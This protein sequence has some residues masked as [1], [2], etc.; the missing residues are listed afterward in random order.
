[1][2]IEFKETGKGGELP[3]LIR[4]FSENGIKGWK[5]FLLHFFPFKSKSRNI[6]SPPRLFREI[7]RNPSQS[8]TIKRKSVFV[9]G[10]NRGGGDRGRGFFFSG[11]KID[12][13][14]RFRSSAP[15]FC[16]FLHIFVSVSSS[17]L[18]ELCHKQRGRKR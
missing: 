16:F 4:S 9:C 10:K 18:S 8:E 1:M 12:F 17:P 14:P 11:G 6:I 15:F 3:K 2:E 5:R 7:G 13:R